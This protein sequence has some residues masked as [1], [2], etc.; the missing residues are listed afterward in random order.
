MKEQELNVHKTSI[1]FFFL[2][3]RLGIVE[4]FASETRTNELNLELDKFKLLLGNSLFEFS[5]QNPYVLKA[6]FDKLFAKHFFE[7]FLAGQNLLW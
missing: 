7:Y 3:P 4:C 1:V 6:S 2:D 5:L